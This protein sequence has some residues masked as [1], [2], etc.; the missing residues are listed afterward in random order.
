MPQGG[1]AAS[2]A[3]SAPRRALLDALVDVFAGTGDNVG[4]RNAAVE[5]LAGAGRPATLALGA[6]MPR[7]DADGKKLAVEALG[8]G[9]DPAALDALFVALSDPDENVRQG[10]IE[11]IAGIGALARDRVPDILMARLGDSDRP[12]CGT[13]RSK[14]AHRARGRHPLGPL[15]SPCL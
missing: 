3:P 5:V 4:L 2:P 11:A 9:R 6:A 13:P 10:A 8:R 12:S 15:S 14:G 1:H 7:L